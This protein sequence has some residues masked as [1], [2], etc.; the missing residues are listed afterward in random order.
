MNL[1]S[2]GYPTLRIDYPGCGDSAGSPG[3][4]GRVDAWRNSVVAASTWLAEST[5]ARVAVIGLG[6]GGLIAGAA[7]EHG[8]PIDEL[9]VWASPARGRTFLREQRAFASLQSSRYGLTDDPDADALP[10]GWMEVGGFVMSAETIADLG[11]LDIADMDLA[12]LRR[13][14]VLSRDG[15]AADERWGRIGTGGTDVSFGSGIGWG[16]MCFHPER[17]EPPLEVFDHVGSWLSS[18]PPAWSAPS[19]SVPRYG[20]DIADHL[21][22]VADGTAIQETP[23]CLDLPFGQSFAILA[24]PVEPRPTDTCAVF[25]N[26]GAVR[27]TGPNRLWVEAARS[28]AARGIPTLR[29][30]FEGI[31]DSDGDASMYSESGPFYSPHR[32]EHGRAVLDALEAQG[33]GPRFALIGLCGGAYWAFNCAAVDDRVF[34]SIVLNPRALVWAP[35]LDERREARQVERL[36]ERGSWQRIVHGDIEVAR[37]RS[38]GRAIVGQAARSASHVPG[39]LRDRRPIPAL[40]VELERTLDRL[41]DSGTRVVLAFSGDEVVLD[42]LERDGILAE[43]GRW[44][45]ATIEALPG[46]D[47]TVRP[48]SAQNAVLRLLDREMPRRMQDAPVASSIRDANSL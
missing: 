19:S 30:D 21:D 47:H 27:R 1:A 42:E 43:L 38:I 29:V 20:T 45:N 9:V 12:G 40:K 28:W 4:G 26:A 15:L 39:R 10:D 32:G 36:L 2:L 37:F 46:S 7:L 48:I 8:A 14:L 41:R 31:G 16:A 17:Y 24:Q 35:D 23:L 3:D 6:L 11:R 25:L 34:G 5:G 22:L 13:A 33:F 44:P 18:V